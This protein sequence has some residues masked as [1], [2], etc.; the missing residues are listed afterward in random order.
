MSLWGLLDGPVRARSREAV[1]RRSAPAGPAGPGSPTTRHGGSGRCNCA[2]GL[3]LTHPSPPSRVLELFSRLGEHLCGVSRPGLTGGEAKGSSTSA[4][5]GR[6]PA[7]ITHRQGLALQ[8]SRRWPGSRA[9]SILSTVQRRRPLHRTAM[10][11]V[12]GMGMCP[13]RNQQT[14]RAGRTERARRATPFEGRAPT[15]S[16]G[17][18]TKRRAAS[19]SRC[20]GT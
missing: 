5:A 7:V 3:A 11:R 20:C 8:D 4:L 14:S 16:E 17:I 1:Y 19:G 12:P 18:L 9:R 13:P 2:G 6:R 15:H 10:R